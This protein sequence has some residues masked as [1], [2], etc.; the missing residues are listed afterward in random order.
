MQQHLLFY[1]P[2]VKSPDSDLLQ[3]LY[4]KD[5]DARF[6][7]ARDIPGYITEKLFDCLFAG[8]VPIYWGEPNIQSIVPKECFIDFRHF[9][10]KPD[11]YA[12]LYSYINTMSEEAYLTYQKAG[13]ASSAQKA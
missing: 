4:P 1:H 7:N 3:D 12:A 6:E 11:P 10:A 9:L 13:A 8:C 2:Y 5:H